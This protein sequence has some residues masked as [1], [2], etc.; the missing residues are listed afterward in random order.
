MGDMKDYTIIKAKVDITK[1][2]SNEFELV[3][4][5]LG[6]F[7]NAM[8][9]NADVHNELI[10]LMCKQVSVAERDAFKFGFDMAVKLMHDYCSDEEE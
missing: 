2:R 9:L 1:G 5:H 10:D 7:I 3:A 4:R 8:D 6:R